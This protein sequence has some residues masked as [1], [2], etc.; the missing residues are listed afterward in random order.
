MAR[1]G[2]DRATQ[3]VRRAWTSDT[4]YEVRAQAVM[5]LAK[6]DQAG[7]RA[8]IAQGLATPSYQ[9]TITNSAYGAIVQANDTTFIPQI[10]SAAGTAIEPS[11]VLAILGARGNARALDLVVNHLDDE[12]PAVRRW[13]LTAITNVL[14]DTVAAARLTAVKDQLR[15]ADS[16]AAV[17][18]A[19]DQLS[20]RRG[21]GGP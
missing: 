11:Y 21:T 9:N 20:A 15:H 6:L 13:A 17:Q 7:R 18:K 4:S 1:I 19:I 2:G 14:P 5:A 10:D 3:L 8:A 16:K 12:R